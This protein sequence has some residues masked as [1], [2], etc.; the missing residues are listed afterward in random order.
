MASFGH[1]SSH[2]PVQGL[3]EGNALIELN[4]SLDILANVFPN[5]LPEVFREMLSIFDGDS[6]LHS[7]LDQLL[8]HRE[9]W[10]HGR[11][12][13]NDATNTEGTEHCAMPISAKDRFRSSSYRSAVRKLLSQEF[14]ELNRSILEAIM[15]EY[16]YS[17]T[18]S[19]PALQQIEAKCWRKRAGAFFSR[20]TRP[21][22]NKLERHILV[23]WSKMPAGEVPR[24]PSL[25]ESGDLELDEE[26]YNMIIKP[27]LESARI[28]QE[29]K[30]WQ[31]AMELN[32][33]EA[34][35]ADAL[36]EC[37][38]CF[39][40][41]TFEELAACTARGHLTCLRCLHHAVS[42]ALFGQSWGCNVDHKRGQIVC[43][44]LTSEGI[45]SGCIPRE[46]VRRAVWQNK[47]G[48]QTWLMFESRL[49][50]EA[51]IETSTL[52]VRCPFCPYAEV[53]DVYFSPNSVHYRL[54]PV[55]LTSAAFLIITAN[56]L[57][58][59]ALYELLRYLPLIKDLPALSAVISSSLDRQA[60]HK[61]L[62]RRFQCRSP[63]CSASS[64]LDCSQHWRDPHVCYESATT[65]LRI[66]VESARTAALK[67]VC[68]R[69]A[70]GFVKESGC[71]RMTCICGY[72][73]CYICR[74]GLGRDEGGEA[75]SHFCQH[76]RPGG[77]R[78]RDCDKCDLYKS[79]DDEVL[80]K[81]A[82]QKAEKEWREREGM[83]GVRGLGGEQ[84]GL[85]KGRWWKKERERENVVQ[86]FADWW[87]GRFV[88]C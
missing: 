53:D 16:N 8:K 58:L 42:E 28:D 79:D 60:R 25:R 27:V 33:A 81:M 26:I 73:M 86:D 74:Q 70:L 9:M 52:L 2:K 88:T 78:C 84:D 55:T 85:A 15:A 37:Q 18:L 3:D 5:V 12:R 57:P 17:Y 59:L 7:V 49:A 54:S 72:T 36:H 35:S 43:L 11:W 46:F 47:A 75:Y 4:K 39:S 30:D 41:V 61:Y 64:C 32:E 63:T 71:N 19:R 40:H 51:L 14:R 29:S 67:R 65:S 77:G 76:F 6:R 87:I 66:T 56:F 80:V 24:A 68:P 45:C 62:S 69:C 1:L 23:T 34:V 83:I 48:A 50:A 44:A 13:T 20:L 10:I 31:V 22:S 38:C 21:Q 82:G